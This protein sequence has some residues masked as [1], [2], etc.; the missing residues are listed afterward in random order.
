MNSKN[1]IGTGFN[2]SA[3]LFTDSGDSFIFLYQ[4]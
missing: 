3:R 2:F 4:R 1:L